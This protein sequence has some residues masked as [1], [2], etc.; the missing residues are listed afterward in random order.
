[1]QTQTIAFGGAAWTLEARRSNRGFQRWAQNALNVLW[2]PE[3]HA[4]FRPD[5]AKQWLR[6]VKLWRSHPLCLIG[7]SAGCVAVRA[8]AGELG[9]DYVEAIVAVDGWCVPFSGLE[10]PVYRLSH[11][12]ATHANGV[13]W[14]GG[15]AQFYAAPAVGHLHLWSQPEQVVGW[16]TGDR[17]A[18]RTTAALFLL[19]VL[20]NPRRA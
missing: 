13:T 2:Y 3:A 14:G 9:S 10:M 7:F 4:P 18:E 1:M 5:L 16:R 11:D 19:D 12:R 6:Q 17:E 15:R 8:I 20:N